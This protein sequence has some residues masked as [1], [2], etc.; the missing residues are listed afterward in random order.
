LPS[1]ITTLPI[2]LILEGTMGHAIQ[3]IIVPPEPAAHAASVPEA[4]LTP[5]KAAGLAFVPMTDDLFERLTTLFP[6]PSGRAYAEFWKLSPSGSLWMKNISA[7]GR[8]AYV[9]TEYFGG[10]GRQAAAVW[11]AGRLALG[12]SQGPVGP[13]NDALR[14]LGVARTQVDDEFTEAGLNHYR[15]NDDWL[16]G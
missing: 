1:G 13:I 4:T 15:S 16:D 3:G 8:V 10:I 6:A 7:A 11:E 2:F 14:F 9:E 5:L 12:P